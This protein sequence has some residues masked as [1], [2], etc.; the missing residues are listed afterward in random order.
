MIA[1]L[2][3]FTVVAWIFAPWRSDRRVASWLVFFLVVVS[4]HVLGYP[5]RGPDERF[6]WIRELPV[7]N[8]EGIS[9]HISRPVILHFSGSSRL[10]SDENLGRW[11]ALVQHVLAVVAAFWTYSLARRLVPLELALLSGILAGTLSP[12]S[13]MSQTVMS[14]NPNSVRDGRRVVF[15]PSSG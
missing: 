2:V 5:V 11:V 8:P 3:A 15:R 12:I 14:E 10:S 7:G 13:A 9:E 4:R 1:A 6:A